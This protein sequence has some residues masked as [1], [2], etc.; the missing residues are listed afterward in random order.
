MELDIAKGWRFNTAD[1]SIIASGKKTHRGSI[2]LIRCPED[3]DKW[4]KL[5]AD[6]DDIDFDENA[7]HLYVNGYGWTFSEALADANTN[8]SKI[9]P[10]N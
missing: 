6:M 8:A 2:T 3:A 1:F 7:P 10:I 9:K 4:R 5:V